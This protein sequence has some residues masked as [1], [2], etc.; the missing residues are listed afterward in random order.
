MDDDLI[1]SVTVKMK[2]LNLD[3]QLRISDQI[4][5]TDVEVAKTFEKFLL[6]F[7]FRLS[8]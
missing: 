7:Q 4:V 3:C 8:G 1:S 5:K 6:T 2:R